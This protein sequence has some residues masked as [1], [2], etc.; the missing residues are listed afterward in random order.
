VGEPGAR[1]Q[2]ILDLLREQ[3]GLAEA[4]GDDEVM[5]AQTL[6]AATEGV[7]AGPTACTALAATIRLAAAG[8]IPRSARVVVLISETGLKGTYPA[9][10]RQVSPAD[11]E[12]IAESIVGQLG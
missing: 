10:E 1:G 4:V 5:A 11:P 7:W 9:V 2:W 6:L 3:D 12:A 8:H